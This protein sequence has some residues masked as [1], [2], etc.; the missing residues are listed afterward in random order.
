MF[1]A[2]G[3]FLGSR[4]FLIPL[5]VVAF[6]LG[7]WWF[8]SSITSE[9][10]RL[11]SDLAKSEAAQEQTLEAAKNLRESVEDW[12]K[13]MDRLEKVLD[14]MAENQLEALRARERIAEMYNEMDVPKVAR[15]NPDATERELNAAASDLNRMLE[16]ASRGLEF[17]GLRSLTL[18]DSGSTSA[19]A[20]E[21]SEGEVDGAD[22]GESG[23]PRP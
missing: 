18:G 21:D 2:I 23:E 8:V 16:Q 12:S 6:I 20:S 11:Q 17:D 5:A 22:S 3:A 7:G 14:Q 10:Q 13:S 4:K 1:G 9:N 15:E 19:G